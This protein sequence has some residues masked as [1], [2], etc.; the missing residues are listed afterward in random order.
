MYW[1]A[2]SRNYKLAANKTVPNDEYQAT[3][4]LTRASKAAVGTAAEVESLNFFNVTCFT[5]T[6][7]CMNHTVPELMQ[8]DPGFD[9][10]PS[11]WTSVDVLG[12]AMWFSVLTDLGR[13]QTAVPNMLVEPTLL[14][15]LTSNYT[16]EIMAWPT[17]NDS[18]TQQLDPGLAQASFD[19]NATPLPDLNASQSFLATNYVCQVPKLKSAGTLVYTVLQ[20]DLV[21]LQNAYTLFVFIVGFLLA[22]RNPEANY[23][24]GC[25]E[26]MGHG[27]KQSNNQHVLSSGEAGTG[28]DD[29]D[30]SSSSTGNNKEPKGYVHLNQNEMHLP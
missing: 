18:I 17:Y 22:R 21:Y 11:I 24:D 16:N 9:P 28:E 8:G 23:C 15:N 1:L 25:R 27:T 6:S 26:A 13:S 29:H 14:A 12:K 5:E 2:L 4:T 20:A 30:T 7:Y 10:Y 19:P 3:I